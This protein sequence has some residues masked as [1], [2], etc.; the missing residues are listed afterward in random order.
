ME[1]DNATMFQAVD[2]HP[3]VSW[4]SVG[5]QE[6]GGREEKRMA[7]VIKT[8][9]ALIHNNTTH[10]TVGIVHFNFNGWRGFQG[11]VAA[12]SGNIKCDITKKHWMIKMA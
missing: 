9:D 7:S 5:G 8:T 1:G 4:W 3:V 11:M 6:S 12:C 2:P 10:N